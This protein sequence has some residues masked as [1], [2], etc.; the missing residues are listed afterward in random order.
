MIRTT[1]IIIG[2]GPAGIAAAVQLKR[3]GIDF[4]LF[5][6][7]SI[8]GLLRN[9]NEVEN[10]L[11]FPA[12]ISGPK[13]TSLLEKHLHSLDI[14][15]IF[16]EVVSVVSRKDNFI[17][18]TRQDEYQSDFLIIASGTKPRMDDS[19]DI[20][21]PVL[22]Y[23]F[24]EIAD[25]PLQ[26]IKEAV[27]IGSGDAAFDYALN[28]SR[29]GIKSKIFIRGKTCK[30]IPLLC[31]KA[32]KN[33]N[34]KVYYGQKLVK[35]KKNDIAELIFQNNKGTISVFSNCIFFA[36]GREPEISFAAEGILSSV[37]AHTNNE[38]MFLIGD[39]KNEIFRQVSIAAGDGI[40]TAMKIAD[41]LKGKK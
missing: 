3:Y 5:E 23:I 29:H 35:I 13:L 19:V 34:I 17:V 33:E 18:K 21:A 25:A 27:I 31:Q 26:K 41:K 6:K 10:Y 32:E 8:G 24:Y 11:G 36:I 12:G 14:D 37:T 9:A 40:L 15:V 28:L 1:V 22:E 16:Q 20:E 30:A 7:K 4:L 2:A 38:K 39:V